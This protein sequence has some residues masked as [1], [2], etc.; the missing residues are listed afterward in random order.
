LT[1]GSRL[2]LYATIGVVVVLLS[3]VLIRFTGTQDWLSRIEGFK[4]RKEE[5][6]RLRKCM[7]EEMRRRHDA[8]MAAYP[9][10]Y[11]LFAVD[12]RANLMPGAPRFVRSIG[13]DW[14][15]ARV[16]RID[17]EAVSL[18]A[19]GI[20]YKD[21]ACILIGKIVTL[22]KRPAAEASLCRLAGGNVTLRCLNDG[23]GTVFCIGISPK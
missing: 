22:A 2:G 13:V 8:L 9:W 20:Y 14:G 7:E 18:V 23:V 16:V 6:K 12:E 1:R 21:E 5:A 15:Q 3:I 19:P 11:A 10:G 4:A 17:E